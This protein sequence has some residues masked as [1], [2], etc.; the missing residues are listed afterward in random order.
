MAGPGFGLSRTKSLLSAGQTGTCRNLRG[1][2]P[3]PCFR[4]LSATMISVR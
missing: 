1:H 2:I 3:R 4:H